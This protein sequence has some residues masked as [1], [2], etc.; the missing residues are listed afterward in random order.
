[1]ANN[2]WHERK[3]D[4]PGGAYGTVTEKA[5][6]WHWK[7]HRL[8]RRLYASGWDDSEHA[9]KSSVTYT[10][11]AFGFVEDGPDDGGAG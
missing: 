5:G 2:G 3:K 4:Y 11:R 6:R 7:L 10:A 9:A 1:M 8:P